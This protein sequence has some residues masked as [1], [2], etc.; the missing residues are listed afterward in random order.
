MFIQEGMFFFCS[1]SEIVTFS[2]LTPAKINHNC[3]KKNLLK[4]TFEKDIIY[5]LQTSIV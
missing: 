1:I 3:C 2:D 4:A 5:M